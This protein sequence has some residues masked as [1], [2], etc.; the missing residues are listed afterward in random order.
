MKQFLFYMGH[1]A[2][3]HNV[4][5]LADDL[6]QKGHQ[7]LFV[8]RE[9]DV[10]FKLL[11]GCSYETIYL[12]PKTS[13]STIALV[14]SII[15]R[16]L[17]ML[18]ICLKYKPDFLI[19]TDIVIT[20]VGKLLGIPSFVLNEDDAKE[21]PFL[22]KF[23]F[24]FSTGVF[25][26][27]SCDISPYEHKKIEYTGYHELAYLHPKYFT[28]N[29]ELI[30]DKIDTSKPYFILRFSDLN[31]HHDKGKY[32]ISEELAIEIIEL[33]KPIGNI[34]IT[35]EK[36]LSNRFEP[37][38]ISIHPKLMHHALSFAKLYIGDSQ[39]MAAEAAI[40][41][42]YAI[43]INDFAGKLGYLIDLENYKLTKAFLPSQRAEILSE[44]KGFL[45]D[46]NRMKNIE[47]HRKK[48][49][50]ERIDTTAFWSWFFCNYPESLNT[51]R[52]DLNFAN[53]FTFLA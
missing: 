7:I 14:F 43:R 19:G 32:G 1:P 52:N 2:H 37:Y 5:H 34:Y 21:V 12:K 36:P 44:I 28:P 17:K 40:L 18:S 16:Q 42:T 23:G 10:L 9:K 13:N 8:A 50:S 26:P 29:A 22:A 47:I 30:K 35:S 20:H 51:C 27:K 45:L 6:S 39:T 48:M 31:A 46:Q 15:A 33:L 41:G 11:E 4:K 53:K 38:R 3:Y 49:L 24:G 25:S